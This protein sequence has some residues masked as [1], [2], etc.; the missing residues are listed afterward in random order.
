MKTRLKTI[1]NSRRTLKKK[2]KRKAFSQKRKTSISTRKKRKNTNC[3][4]TKRGGNQ[5]P[6]PNSAY[7][8]LKNLPNQVNARA[9]VKFGSDNTDST[10][11][12]NKALREYTSNLNKQHSEKMEAKYPDDMINSIACTECN[13]VNCTK[14]ECKIPDSNNYNALKIN[15][16]LKNIDSCDVKSDLL[17][18]KTQN[19]IEYENL[20]E[21]PIG[22]K[23]GLKPVYSKFPDFLKKRKNQKS[24][25]YTNDLLS[26]SYTLKKINELL[27]TTSDKVNDNDVKSVVN[28]VLKKYPKKYLNFLK[29]NVT[30]LT[31][32]YIPLTPPD[33]KSKLGCS[34]VK[35]NKGDDVPSQ[36]LSCDIIQYALD[37]LNELNPNKGKWEYVVNGRE[38]KVLLVPTGANEIEKEAE[39]EAEAEGVEGVEAEAEGVEAEAEAERVEENSRFSTHQRNSTVDYQYDDEE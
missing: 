8:L 6:G 28:A 11:W 18:F 15:Q 25:F 4:T 34:A 26:K 9:A 16:L 7:Y 13:R 20:K 29:S 17:A 14:C 27:N 31:T 37:K 24:V 21:I 39:A 12:R 23:N 36:I 2:G 33:Y 10:S 5:L 22:I 19:H 38:K 30:T 1:K 32:V 3:R 35:Y